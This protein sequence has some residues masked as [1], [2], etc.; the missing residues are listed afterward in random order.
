MAN[1]EVFSWSFSSS[2]NLFFLKGVIPMHM[3]LFFW[4]LVYC[5]AVNRAYLLYA[6]IKLTPCL[7]AELTIWPNLCHFKT[8]FREV[9]GANVNN[10][11]VKKRF[12]I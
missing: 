9:F 1:F 7:T 4:I 3:A 11:A 12:H 10:A 2:I 5:V 8:F 6:H